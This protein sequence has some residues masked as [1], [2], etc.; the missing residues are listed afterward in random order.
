M[1]WTLTKK[2]HDRFWGDLRDDE[3]SMVSLLALPVAP[4][5]DI[6]LYLRDVSRRV[7]HHFQDSKRLRAKRERDAVCL[8]RLA[9]E[10][11][12]P[13]LANV[14]NLSVVADLEEV[15]HEI[16]RDQLGRPLLSIESVAVLTFEQ[17]AGKNAVIVTFVYRRCERIVKDGVSQDRLTISAHTVRLSVNRLANC[18][19]VAIVLSF[20]HKE[21]SG[22]DDP[23][24]YI[25]GVTGRLVPDL[26]LDTFQVEPL[27]LPLAGTRKNEAGIRSTISE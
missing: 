24:A 23:V 7:W 15:C 8:E 19:D 21:L 13:Y 6:A 5:A 27:Q 18:I 25:Q 22:V 9:P 16:V 3:L 26:I 17:F 14:P 12:E 10:R 2:F 4:I 1:K 11:I 20:P